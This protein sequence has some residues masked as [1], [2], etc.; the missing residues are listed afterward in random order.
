[1]SQTRCQGMNLLLVPL[2]AIV[3]GV[4]TLHL[5]NL[6]IYLLCIYCLFVTV[7][8]LHYGVCVVSTTYL[9]KYLVSTYLE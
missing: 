4:M 2:V 9:R 8:H 1:M 3:A 6:E 7:A 5:G